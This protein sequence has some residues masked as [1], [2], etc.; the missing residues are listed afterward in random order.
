MS[1]PSDLK[2][3]EAPRDSFQKMDDAVAFGG[4]IGIV[5]LLL[6]FWGLW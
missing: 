3:Y 6:A 5:I 4:F 2:D 1:L